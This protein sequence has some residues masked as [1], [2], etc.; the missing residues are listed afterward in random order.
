MAGKQGLDEESYLKILEKLHSDYNT[1]TD[2]EPVEDC[3]DD[4]DPPISS[5]LTSD[6]LDKSQS[7]DRSA[8]GEGE[9][10]K[11]LAHS[12]STI[13]QELCDQERPST[14]TNNQVL[15]TS[16]EAMRLSTSGQGRQQSRR[17][18]RKNQM[19]IRTYIFRYILV[20]SL[21]RIF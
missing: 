5:Y 21:P 15:S 19:P 20:I 16:S 9:V 12:S 14:S 10:A 17:R 18:W 11:I 8:Q 6:P 1:D 7:K 13:D 3:E 4:L 2:V